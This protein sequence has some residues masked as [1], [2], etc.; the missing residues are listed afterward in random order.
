MLLVNLNELVHSKGSTIKLK[1]CYLGNPQ[2][3]HHAGAY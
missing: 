3:L 1:V 2:S